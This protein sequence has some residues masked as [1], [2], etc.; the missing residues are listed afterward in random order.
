[1]QYRCI[2]HNNDVAEG[3]INTNIQFFAND[4]LCN[5]PS[6]KEVVLSETAYNNLK[7]CIQK[8]R[9][10]NEKGE[11]EVYEYTRFPVILLETIYSEKEKEKLRQQELQ[12]EELI[13]A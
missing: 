3:E 6:G 13:T 5:I 1:M 4:K 10:I 7:N 2:V 12:N 11:E 9:R 8:R